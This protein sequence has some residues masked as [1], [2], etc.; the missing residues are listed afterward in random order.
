MND[1]LIQNGRIID[2]TGAPA[3][4][5]SLLIRDGKIAA[6]N[7]ENIPETAR[8]IDAKGRIVAPGFI[9]THSHSS[10]MVNVEPMLSPKIYQGITTEILAQDGMGPA[11]VNE[12]TIAPWKKAMS[13]LEGEWDFDWNWKTVDEYLNQVDTLPLGP[14][15]AYLAP[16]G[17]L[18]MVVMGLDN[19]KPTRD[20]LEEMKEELQKAF[21]AGAYG[22]ST[23]MIY[24]PCVYADTSEFIE[25]G[26]V[27]AKNNGVFVTHQR[28]EADAILESMDEIIEIG[29]KSGCRVHFSHFKCCGKN[30]WDK[31][32][33]ILQ[34]LDDAKAKGIHV[35]FDSYPYV[36]GSTM[37]SVILPPWAHDGGTEKLLE[38]LNDEEQRAKMKEDIKNGIPG[39]DNFIDFAGFDGIF[40]PFVKNPES[41]Q[42][43]GLSLQELGDKT[44]KEP[45]DAIFD[46]IRDE[47][48]IIGLVDFYGTE[49]HI[50]EFLQRPEQN[51]CT[52]GIIGSKPHPRLYGAFTRVLAKYVRDEGVVSL[53]EAIR[54]MSG[55]PAEVL[56]MKDRGLLKEGYAADIL[57][58]D[59]QTVQDKGS[60]TDPNHLAEGIDYSMVNGT[61][62]IEEGRQIDGR[63]GQVLRFDRTR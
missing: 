38:R 29:E 30:N 17:N 58:I 32:P 6:I 8:V 23:G 37:M 63:A 62:I 43:V 3:Y 41:E 51:V 42:Y 40:I 10:L 56:G 11:P 28:S 9:D 14:N 54:K 5:G 1:L 57:L 15:L 18:R 49:D 36:A 59:P 50:K 20:E 35:S 19:R 61:I 7:P 46:L 12:E 60:Y 24:P 47:E 33:A 25:L 16:H 53:E 45:L 27:I 31:V 44:G 52:D 26:K 34:K 2:G 13:G 22:M 4:T 21:D 55:K 48:N 39:W